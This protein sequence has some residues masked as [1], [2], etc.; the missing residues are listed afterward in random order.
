MFQVSLKSAN[1]G[2]EKVIVVG[3]EPVFEYDNAIQQYTSEIVGTKY[4][5]ILHSNKYQQL[6]VKING[7]DPMPELTNEIL[8]EANANGSP[9][10]VVF[11]EGHV[12]SGEF[13]GRDSLTA[14]A[15][16]AELANKPRINVN[17]QTAE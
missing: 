3:K 15:T 17:K 12:R 16:S 14:K 9:I 1:E 2:N 5:I 13:N 6:S 4:H 8:Q 11:K 10:L 7:E